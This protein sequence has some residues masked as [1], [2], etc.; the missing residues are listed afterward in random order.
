MNQLPRVPYST[1]NWN[2][3]GLGNHRA[4]VRV[5]ASAAAGVPAAAVVARIPWRRADEAPEKKAVRVVAAATGDPVANAVCLYL[6]A[7]QGEIAFEPVCGPG[8]Y[9]VYYLPQRQAGWQHQ[10]E[11]CYLPPTATADPAWRARCG[12][13]AGGV[14]V[15]LPEA[16]VVAL[17]AVDDFHRLDPME[18]PATDGEVQ[19]L[20]ARHPEQ[21]YLVFAEDRRYP[22][23]L[24]DRLPVR[25]VD[26]G[27]G[28]AFEGAADPNEYYTFQLALFAARGPLHEVELRFANLT[29]PDGAHL[30]AEAF[31]CVNQRGRDWV[32]REFRK[33]VGV[34]EGRVQALWIG[35]RIPE[36][37][38]PGIYRGRVTVSAEG[39]PDTEVA[40][41]L[42]V[43]AQVRADG[44]DGDL[45]RQA[46]LRW[47]DS[48][49]GLD[50]ETVEPYPA[51]AVE[52]RS[53][54]LLGHTVRL[55]ALGLPEQITTRYDASVQGADGP[56]QEMLARPVRF[57]VEATS[58][59]EVVTGGA[60]RPERLGSG[61]VQ[62]RSAGQ[63]RQLGV[64]VTATAESDGYLTYS[65]EVS[66]RAPVEV[67]DLRLEIP[68]RK[69][70]ARYLMGMGYRGGARQGDWQWQWSE[71]ANHM[72]WIGDACGGIQ[73][74]LMYDDDVWEIYSLKE[75][76]LP[77]SWG[78]GGRGGCRV[79]EREGEV[80]LCAHSGA[81]R[82]ERGARLRFRFGLLLTPF[83]PI[84]RQHWDWR[85][86]GDGL[87][88][89]RPT[90]EV[91]AAGARIRHLHHGNELNPHI[92]YPFARAAELAAYAR[93]VH[94]RD[95]RLIIYYTVRE[96]SNYAAELW[97]FRSLGDE[98][99][100]SPE[101]FRLADHF[102]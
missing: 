56:D 60:P 68:L 46:R 2:P 58:G 34:P 10:P 24:P 75:R 9:Y 7:E 73:L 3:D 38:A 17:E 71:H 21:P 41:A 52:G 70:F 65:I 92:N 93:Q 59:V 28:R 6:S 4:V 63:G 64:A 47:L 78:N 39:V 74:K 95:M 72:I 86:Y 55:G 48:D 31:R 84:D 35:L 19:A 51:A 76:G 81:R 53:V 88:D 27:P 87:T 29:G 54:R 61:A 83:H 13:D 102:A 101:G 77:E 16:E 94:D 30:P 42:T 18:V 37:A 36:D 20:L 57:A 98:I 14:P 79:V 11:T 89:L 69:A 80:L 50:T 49:L 5:P 91:A 23:R 100:R 67:R 32:G 45:W 26:A 44:G 33:V 66:V 8:D 85:Y 12:L 97:A 99:Y 1:S 22:V 90:D 15:G 96:L 40:L 43:S 62:W 25:W 82:L